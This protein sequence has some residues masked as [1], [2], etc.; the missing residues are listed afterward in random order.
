MLKL[1]HAVAFFV[2]T[3]LAV[4]ARCYL[5]DTYVS[6]YE[7]FYDP[8]GP[9]TKIFDIAILVIGFSGA[10][11][12]FFSPAKEQTV[13]FDFPKKGRI[14][15]A[16]STL[17]FC[18]FF[19]WNFVK[20]DHETIMFMPAGVVNENANGPGVA[21][22]VGAFQR[23]FG[24]FVIVALVAQS[25]VLLMNKREL[26]TSNMFKMLQVIPVIWGIIEVMRII[27]AYTTIWH[28]SEH[29]L[30]LMALAFILVTLSVQASLLAFKT[31]SLG[32]VRRHVVSGLLAVFF[33]CLA[34]IPFCISPVFTDFRENDFY[35]NISNLFIAS[36][37]LYIL[38]FLLCVS[39]KRGTDELLD[40]ADLPAA[41]VAET[42]TAAGSEAEQT[43]EAQDAADAAESEE[44]EEVAG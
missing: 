3:I 14:A 21:A 18:A 41:R 37:G 17:L 31:S 27:M 34:T 2:F 24:L 40:D 15:F 5:V 43:E 7:G 11:F 39:P 23:Y 29:I 26:L 6:M 22:F 30:E 20:N 9:I 32:L 44:V 19:V 1:R 33:S 4:I 28:I 13:N 36:A 10:A 35:Y 16:L 12:I 25:L 38:S 42:N 8:A